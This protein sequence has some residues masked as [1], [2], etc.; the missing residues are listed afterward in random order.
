[1]SRKLINII[2][3]DPEINKFRMKA[4][5]LINSM[6]ELSDEEFQAEASK[7]KNEIDRRIDELYKVNQ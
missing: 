7:I 3:S 4:E 6:E 5:E 1:M 2:N